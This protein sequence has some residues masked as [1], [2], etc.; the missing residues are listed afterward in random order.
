MTKHKHTKARTRRK[1]KERDGR[2]KRNAA[3]CKKVGRVAV[4]P[5]SPTPTVKPTPTVEQDDFDKSM[6]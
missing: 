4:M 6:E 2:V 1:L 3:Q 5:P